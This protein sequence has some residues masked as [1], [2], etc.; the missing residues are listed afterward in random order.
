MIKE[1]QELFKAADINNDGYLTKKEYPGF[2]HPEEFQHMH[3]VIFSCTI[4]YPLFFS[5]FTLLHLI[6]NS[7][8]LK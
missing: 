3:E 4:F 7:Y 6:L 5:F 2:S 1:D 8:K